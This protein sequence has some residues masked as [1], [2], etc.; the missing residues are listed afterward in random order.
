VSIVQ[1]ENLG[2]IPIIASVVLA[3][4]RILHIDKPI[5]VP[6]GTIIDGSDPVA[7]ERILLCLDVVSYIEEDGKTVWKRG[8]NL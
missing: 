7:V 6:S 4:K 1:G 5:I 8:D 2:N 3:G